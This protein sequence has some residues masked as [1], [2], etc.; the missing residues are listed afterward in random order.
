M[1]YG[2]VNADLMTTSD[3]VSA[4]GTY[5]FKNRIINGAMVISQ[6]G[7]SFSNPTGGVYTLDRW[8]VRI[9]N[10]SVSSTITQSSTAPAGFINSLYLN[11]ATG[12]ASGSTDRAQLYQGI[13]GFNVADLGWGTANA[14]TVTLSFWVYSSKT[15][16]FGGAFQ[17][18]AGNR[19]YPFTYTISSAN[20]WTQISVTVAGDTSGTWTTDNSA[21]IQLLFDLGMGS[22]YL[23]T[24]GAWAG[25]DYRGA[26]GDTSIVATS[27]ATFYITG[28]Q[29]EKGS[30]AT[31]FDY[32]PYGTELQL[33]QRYL[34]AFNSA[35]NTSY[36]TVASGFSS[37]TSLAYFA[38]P[39]QVPARVQPTGL[40]TATYNSFQ[41]AFLAS[42]SA[43]TSLSFV[44][45][46][47]L[48]G[49]ISVGGTYVA[50]QGGILLYQNGSSTLGQL[51]FTGCE[52]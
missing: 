29:L 25:A 46:S 13:E 51:L 16:Q 18:N 40:T 20:T 30:T 45:A 12:S 21:G 28:V 41:T 1:A 35:L 44:D 52:L 9:Q 31:S 39:F 11:V 8:Y 42:A 22:T 24:A 50:G 15:G 7:T 48:A 10:A 32:R 2:T 37:S 38:F 27:G 26:T 3:G 36:Q 4:A 5:G 23:G 33:C 19:S 34:P 49:R 47:T 6:R 14:K 43:A 17:N